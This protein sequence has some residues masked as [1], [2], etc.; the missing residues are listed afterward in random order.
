MRKALWT[1][2][3]L[4]APY[5]IEI[6]GKPHH[7]P[8][9]VSDS[10]RRWTAKMRILEG[11]LGETG[12]FAAGDAFSFADIPLGL[13]AHRWFGGDFERPDLPNVAAYCARV[14]VR[15]AAIAHFDPAT[16]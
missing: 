6:W 1:A 2:D 13:S 4:G 14:K 8:A 11:R 15:P 9:A 10:V 7:D 12:A 16:P 5:E 3:E